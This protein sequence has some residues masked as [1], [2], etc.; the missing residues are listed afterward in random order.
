MANLQ[1]NQIISHPAQG[2]ANRFGLHPAIALFTLCLDTMLFGAEAITLGL[3]LPLSLLASAVVGYVTY[4]G[5][6]S[7][8]GD[9][10]QSAKTKAVMLAF[11]TFVP[12]ALPSYLYLPAGL[13]G[14][15]R[16]RN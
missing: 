15:F 16:K 8:F 14:M 9:D 2:F 6:Q 4:T 1:N 7:W 3:S 5:Q 11:L 12:T 10:A 13:I